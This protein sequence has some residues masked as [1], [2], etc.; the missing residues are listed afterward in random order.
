MNNKPYSDFLEEH[1]SS[2]HNNENLENN[3]SNVSS[4]VSNNSNNQMLN[5]EEID[6]SDFKDINLDIEKD[7]KTFTKIKELKDSLIH[8]AEKNIKNLVGQNIE[9]PVIN[10]NKKDKNKMH[11]MQEELISDTESVDSNTSQNSNNSNNTN[12]SNNTV[13]SALTN[14]L[15]V[16]DI[17]DK[18]GFTLINLRIYVIIMTTLMADGGEVALL[19]IIISVLGDKW[20]LDHYQKGVIGGCNY[21]GS[22]VGAVLS[23]TLSDKYGRKPTF[24]VGIA[25][26]SIF[27]VLTSTA[28]NYY[29]FV[30]YRIIYGFGIGMSI[31]ANSTLTTEVTP[32]SKRSWVLNIL[33]LFFPLGELY[34]VLFAKSFL[35]DASTPD[36]YSNI[37]IMGIEP[38][39]LLVLVV[40]IPSFLSFFLTLIVDES[41]RFLLEQ[42]RYNEGYEILN[43]IRSKSNSPELSYEEK[44]RL[45]QEALLVKKHEEKKTKKKKSKIEN[46]KELFNHKY[47]KQTLLIAVIYIANSMTWNGLTF[48]IPQAIE[49]HGI[50]HNKQN[51][52]AVFNSLIVSALFEI[53]TT[54]MASWLS[55]IKW[56]GRKGA[57]SLSLGLCSLTSLM[58][59]LDL[60]GFKPF[61]V[62]TKFLIVIPFGVLFVYNC[63]VYPTRIRTTAVGTL[64]SVGRISSIF[65]PFIL[66]IMLGWQLHVPFV[67]VSVMCFLGGVAAHFLPVESLGKNLD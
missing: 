47:L 53:P 5:R 3:I 66:Q 19:S 17:I 42:G 15:L 4:S 35:T 45:K 55:E 50:K 49:A 57:M 7:K 36:S 26:V 11:Q 33:W 46:Y 24:I 40:G 51:P 63:E 1:K 31:P 12:S 16:D 37:P 14:N 28:Q 9:L 54:L 30:F 48:I 62:S 25:I 10:I 39:R 6:T 58:A 2:N 23:G 65:S 38:W 41:P 20:N 29:L 67:L 56:L 64:G 34:S 44:E 43:K 18:A 32:K 8:T 60:F 13:N 59:A 61:V 27:A 52:H 22:L 21:I